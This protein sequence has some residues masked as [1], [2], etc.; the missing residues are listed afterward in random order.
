MSPLLKEGCAWSGTKRRVEDWGT[1]ATVRQTKAPL[2]KKVSRV[3]R[4]YAS[5][6]KQPSF[7]WGHR[8]ASH[9][10]RLGPLGLVGGGSK[11]E[12]RTPYLLLIRHPILEVGH[13]GC[14][15]PARRAG[16][17]QAGKEAE[18]WNH[19]GGRRKDPPGS[20]GQEGAMSVPRGRDSQEWEH[21]RK[22]A[23]PLR[24]CS[25]NV[26]LI[27]FQSLCHSSWNAWWRVSTVRGAWAPS[28]HVAVATPI[29]FPDPVGLVGR[30]VQ[31]TKS[32][33]ALGNINTFPTP[34]QGER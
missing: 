30:R 8:Q 28:G 19:R 22:S 15:G 31:C 20:S 17:R 11:R 14:S 33:S 25:L 2:R 13:L 23:F 7:S 18:W 5:A 3:K 29:S 24:L 26:F 6:G 16:A 4:E 9:C 12:R 34:A 1:G 32:C 21:S 10:C 27:E